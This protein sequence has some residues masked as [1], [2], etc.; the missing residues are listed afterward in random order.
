[1]VKA[2]TFTTSVAT[3]ETSAAISFSRTDCMARPSRVFG[4][5]QTPKITR[6]R[7][8]TQNNR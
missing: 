7:T 4:S 3:P 2:T 6:Y 1:M 8:S 5:H